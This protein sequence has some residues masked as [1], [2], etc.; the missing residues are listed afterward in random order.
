MAQQTMDLTLGDV[1]ER[2]DGGVRS[3]KAVRIS[4]ANGSTARVNPGQPLDYASA[5]ADVTGQ[6][7]ADCLAEPV[8]AS[9]RVSAAG[10][11]PS[12]GRPSFPDEGLVVASL[13]GS[14]HRAISGSGAA[15]V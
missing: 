8:P 7:I 6:W 11:P 2:I 10:I 3:K 1:F 5:V 12:S 14:R 4:T 13:R 9:W 15:G